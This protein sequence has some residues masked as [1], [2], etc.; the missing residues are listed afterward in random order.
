[1][2]GDE[3]SGPGLMCVDRGVL[4][5]MRHPTL[6]SGLHR[7]HALSEPCVSRTA[8]SRSVCGRRTLAELHIQDIGPRMLPPSA[9]PGRGASCTYPCCSFPCSALRTHGTL[10]S[11]GRGNH[12]H[13]QIWIEQLGEVLLCG[14]LALLLCCELAPYTGELASIKPEPSAPRTLVHHYTA[15][16]AVKVSHHDLRVSGTADALAQVRPE[17][18]ISLHLQEL[19]ASRLVYLINA[20]EFE[21]VEPDPTASPSTHVHRHTSALIVVMVLEHT[22]HSMIRSSLASGSRV[23]S[24]SLA[25]SVLSGSSFP[26][27]LTLY[28]RQGADV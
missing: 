2:H 21:P 23:V 22:G 18:G 11:P 12:L 7:T 6:G 14:L 9:A 27:R 1:M 16:D 26:A 8:I 28:P 13:G 3:C 19:L 10:R 4:V 5:G 17:C 15:F 25:I 24:V 20:G